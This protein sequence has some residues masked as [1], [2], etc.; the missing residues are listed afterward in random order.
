M[1]CECKELEREHGQGSCKCVHYRESFPNC[2]CEQVS[3]NDYSPGPVEDGE[4]LIRTLYS[5][6]HFDKQTN[7]IRP[8]AFDD[9]R[10]RGLS[11]DRKT[12]IAGR[13]LVAKTLDKIQRDVA[14]G[15]RRDDCW[16]LIVA[17]A[18]SIRLL[19]A[20]E[21]NR[22]FCIYDTAT[23]D[24]RATQTFVKPSFTLREQR[25]EGYGIE[26]YVC[27]FH[28]NFRRTFLTSGKSMNPS[29]SAELDAF[30]AP[31][32]SNARDKLR[33]TGRSHN[34]WPLHSYPASL[35][36]SVRRATASLGRLRRRGSANGCGLP[37]RAD[38]VE[39]REGPVGHNA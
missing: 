9:V 18:R 26:R 7:E 16:G 14:A 11:V 32:E 34:R 8:T 23:G 2:E 31:S 10:R 24:N 33:H 15:K 30:G 22:S 5:S 3:V 17:D 19:L 4:I 20:E 28:E 6:V 25:R 12:H 21:R 29:F 36:C 37:L 38:Y 13:D 39:G 1:T 35:R 27:S